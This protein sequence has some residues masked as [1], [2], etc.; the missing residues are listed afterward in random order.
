[1]KLSKLFTVIA[2]AALGMILAV[3][4]AAAD[5]VVMWDFADSTDGT[6][7]KADGTISFN[8]NQYENAGFL[9]DEACFYGEVTGA[10]PY[11]QLP[12]RDEFPGTNHFIKVKYNLTGLNNW[13]TSFYFTTDTV[14]WS[15]TG[16]YTGFYEGDDGEW[17]EQVFDANECAAWD[18]TVKELRL[19]IFDSGEAGQTA[20]V[21]YVAIFAT[22]ED[23]NAF[24]YAAYRASAVPANA[25]E[26]VEEAPVEAEL[27]PEP[28]PEPEP[29]PTEEIVVVVE[30]PEIVEAPAEATAEA[31]AAA[32]TFDM[33]VI[34]AV[35]AVVSLAGYAVSKKR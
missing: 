14:G 33:A 28:E 15:E 31:P 20:K 8:G 23:A 25:V 2:S 17:T 16:H 32:Q 35:S 12:K 6:L 10:D 22:E 3:S 11:L 19:D 29:V 26:A 34:A 7:Y 9:A 24:D 13:S 5:P 4:V 18:G 21:A 1:M 30:E 27:A